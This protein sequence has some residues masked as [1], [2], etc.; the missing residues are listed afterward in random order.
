MVGQRHGDVGYLLDPATECVVRV[1]LH[2]SVVLL[3]LLE[4]RDTLYARLHSEIADAI[5]AKAVNVPIVYKRVGWLWRGFINRRKQGGFDGLGLEVYKAGEAYDV[6]A[7]TYA[8]ELRQSRRPMW[9][10]TTETNHA[11]KASAPRA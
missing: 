8:S 6:P 2:R 3:D 5:R 1:D 11:R 4:A 9:Y 7:A 10:I